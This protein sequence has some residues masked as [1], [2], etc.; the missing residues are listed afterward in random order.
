MQ[1]WS[2]SES[3]TFL[4]SPTDYSLYADIFYVDGTHRWGFALPFDPKVAGWQQV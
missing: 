2:M 1:G 4:G 3:V